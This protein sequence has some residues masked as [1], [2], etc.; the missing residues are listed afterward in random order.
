MS[1]AAPVHRIDTHL[2]LLYIRIGN[3]SLIGGSQNHRLPE[4]MLL[5][6]TVSDDVER[7]Y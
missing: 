5:A 2:E 3:G 7:P 6:L 1:G 4:A